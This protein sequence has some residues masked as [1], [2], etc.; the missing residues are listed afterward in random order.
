MKLPQLYAAL[1]SMPN[2]RESSDGTQAQIKC[3]ICGDSRH[4]P[5]AAHLSIKIDV[6]PNE[7][8][9]YQCFRASCQAKGALKTSTLQEWGI[10]NLDVLTELAEHN[11][12]VSKTFDREFVSKKQKEYTLVN[13]A[14]EANQAKLSYLNRRLGTNLEAKDLKDL[15]IQLSL[16]DM[17]RIN[18]IKRFSAKQDTVYALDQCCIGFVSMY[19][20]FMICRDITPKMV[21]G[22]RYYVYRISGKPDPND[23]RV[24]C[25]PTEIDLMDPHAAVINVAEGPFSILGAYLNTDLGRDK[26]NSI[27]VANCG[28]QYQ[29]TILHVAKQYGLLRCHINIWSDSEIPLSQYTSLYKSLKNRLDIRSMTVWYNQAAD[30]FGHSKKDID[31]APSTIV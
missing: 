21:T 20:E 13:I 11:R 22:K 10:T 17:L 5:T 30:D 18:E 31:P 7:P 15:K 25:I 19:N 2:Y 29:N 8:V 23:M 27:W 28:A 3:P 6:K 14:N 24:Y 1:R 16:I 26:R 9:L 4:D 12:N